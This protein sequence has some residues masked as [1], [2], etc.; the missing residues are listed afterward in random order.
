MRVV[1]AGAT[2][3]I[4]VPLVLALIDHGHE[5]IGLTRSARSA[6]ENSDLWS[7]AIVADALDAESLRSAARPIKADAVI[8]QMTA[9]TRP[10]IRYRDLNQTNDLRIRGT[11]HLLELATAVGAT[12]FVTQS[13]LGGYGYGDHG[14]AV[15]T[16]D[17]QFAPPGRSAGRERAMAAMRS[18]EQ[19]V[20]TSADVQGVALRYGLFYGPG[21]PLD[22]MLKLLRRRQLPIPRDRGGSLSYVYVPDAARATVAALERGRSGQA[23]NVCDDEPVRWGTF[24]SAVA[25]TFGKPPP[26]RVPA[27]MLRAAPY[28]YA[29]MTSTIRLSNQRAKNELGWLPGAPSYREG[30]QLAREEVVARSGNVGT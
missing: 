21:R 19:Q 9:L 28:A 29:F 24:I 25:E 27:W 4:G 16:E 7:G 20:L 14:E 22:A 18:G 13:F 2:G 23:Y 30:L 11:R 3:A 6:A 1:V 15:L 5:V 10:P 8:H 12:R 26:L 17:N